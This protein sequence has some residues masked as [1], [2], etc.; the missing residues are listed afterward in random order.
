MKIIDISIPIHPKMLLYPG[1]PKVEFKSLPGKTSYLTK[2][3]LATHMGTHLDA[4]RHVFKSGQTVDKIDLDK[5]VGSCRVLDMT[6]VKSSITVTDLKKTK[7]KK[8][9][10]ILVKT[11][12]SQRGLKKFYGDY[13]YLDG[14]AADYLAKKKIR[15]FGIDYLSV[16]KKGGKD[17]RAHNSLLKAGII[18][19]ETINLRNVKPGKYFFVGMPLKLKGLDGSPVRAVLIKS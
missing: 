5:V 12:N 9:E 1:D 16:K 6:H 2:M 13:V 3:T 18:I 8:G 11:K 10:R 7:V 17:L 15:M 19:V 4:P 14:D